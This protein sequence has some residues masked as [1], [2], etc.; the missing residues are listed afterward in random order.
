MK[1]YDLGLG[2]VIQSYSASPRDIE[3]NSRNEE[4]DV[5]GMLTLN[6]IENITNEAL[7]I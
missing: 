6:L 4:P 2:T 1:K 7:K 5:V 3:A